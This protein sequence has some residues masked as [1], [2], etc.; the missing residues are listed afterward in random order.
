MRRTI[1]FLTVVTIVLSMSLSCRKRDAEYVTVALPEKFSSFDTLTT[2]TPPDASADRIRNLIFNSLVKKDANFDYVG[3]LAK[4]IITS[5]DGM[6]ITFKLHD[7]VKFHNGQAFTS[8]D[9]KYT[10]DELFRSESFKSGAFFDTVPADP[11]DAS[12]VAATPT[13]NGNT[14]TKS[15]PTPKEEPKTKRV[16][17]ISSIETPDP[18]TVVFKVTRPALRNQL[19]ANLVAIPIV[20]TGTVAQLKDTP[21]G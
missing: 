16:A 10:F 11:L 14:D 7:G 12:K 6:T 21:I 20:P 17:H 3:E 4:E 19:L 18:F 1:L 8:A 2:V 13:P 5:P 15:A 9:V